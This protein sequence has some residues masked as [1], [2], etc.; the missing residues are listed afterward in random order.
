MTP[1]DLMTF[2]GRAIS[3]FSSPLIF[4]SHV[5]LAFVVLCLVLIDLIAA[6][7]AMTGGKMLDLNA[8][9]GW[10]GP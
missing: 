3:R 8:T 5:T 7:W 6:E 1:R 9:A 2:L 10:T 4:A